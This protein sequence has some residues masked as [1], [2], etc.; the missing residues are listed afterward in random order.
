MILSLAGL[1][2]DW[3]SR[4]LCS[5]EH[6][7]TRSRRSSV[8]ASLW[9]AREE[10][11]QTENLAAHRAAA[12]E[13]ASRVSAV[14]ASASGP[15]KPSRPGCAVRARAQDSDKAGSPLSSTAAR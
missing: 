1:L 4:A 8:A 9:D 14:P 13:N 11:E 6:F 7:A 3:H 2:R 15:V 12:T 5:T 10:T